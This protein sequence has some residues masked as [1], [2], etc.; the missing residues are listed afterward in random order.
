MTSFARS[1]STNTTLIFGPSGNARMGIVPAGNRAGRPV[2]HDGG[3]GWIRQMS[4]TGQLPSP[5]SFP[6]PMG[7]SSGAIATSTEPGSN[8][9]RIGGLGAPPPGG[10]AGGAA[11]GGGGG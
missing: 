5:P 6:P 8:G 10:A 11:G 1:E 9:E 7:G 4:N 2:G 3:D